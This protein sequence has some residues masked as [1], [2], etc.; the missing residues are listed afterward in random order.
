ML[1]QLINHK[2]SGRTVFLCHL[3]DHL[4]ASNLMMGKMDHPTDHIQSN[5]QQL[6]II[7]T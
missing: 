3:S 5:F 2:K 1:E 7:R 6:T 4:A